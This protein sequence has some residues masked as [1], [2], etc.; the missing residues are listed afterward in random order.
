M[1]WDEVKPI[2]FIV[3]VFVLV[4]TLVVGCSAAVDRKT[5]TEKTSE[6]GFPGTWGFW[7]GCRIEVQPGQWIPL[8][9]YYFEQEK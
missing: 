2:L 7:S 6:V 8:S 4:I 3:F 5:C 1:D 9:N